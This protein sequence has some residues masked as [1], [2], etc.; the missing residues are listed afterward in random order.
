MV[1]KLSK[2]GFPFVQFVLENK[3]AIK[4]CTHRPVSNIKS[5]EFFT[6]SIILYFEHSKYGCL[7]YEN[8]IPLI[9]PL[10]PSSSAAIA[11]KH[12]T[13]HNHMAHD[14]LRRLHN[15]DVTAQLIEKATEIPWF[16]GNSDALATKC[17]RTYSWDTRL[18]RIATYSRAHD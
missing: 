6:S 10:S 2:Q 16:H 3:E 15:W 11:T 18:K 4:N 17:H 13:Q 7:Y 12:L 8:T 9:Q 5:L 1:T 14:L